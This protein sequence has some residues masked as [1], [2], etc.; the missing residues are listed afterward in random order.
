MTFGYYNTVKG[1]YLHEH[2]H[3]NEEVWHVIEG[4]LE[5]TIGGEIQIAGPGHVAMVP[6]NT[7]H[8]VKVLSP[9][10]AMVVDHPRR[11]SIGGVK[12]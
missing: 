12:T 6:P 10:R 8:S 5:V 1:A 7:L 3:P 9:G 4:E 2:S 11:E